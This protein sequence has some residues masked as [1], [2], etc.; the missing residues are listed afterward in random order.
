MKKTQVVRVWVAGFL[1][2]GWLGSAHAQ[3]YFTNVTA[4]ANG[5]WNTMANWTNASGGAPIAVN[6]SNLFFGVA[7]RNTNNLANGSSFGFITWTA[8]VT[9]RQSSAGNRY[10][11]NGFTNTSGSR[12]QWLIRT[13]FTNNLIQPVFYNDGQL[14]IGNTIT[15]LTTQAL[16]FDGSGNTTNLNPIYSTVAGVVKTGS[17][18]LTLTSSNAFASGMVLSN[19]LLNINHAYALGPGTFTIAKDGVTNNNSSGAAIVNANNNAIAW[20]GDFTFLGTRDLDLGTGAVTLGGGNRTVQVNA[21]TLALGGAIGDGGN[22]YGII[23][24]GSGVLSLAGANTYGGL[25]DIRTGIVSVATTG[26]LPG[27][28]TAGRY[29]VSNGAALAVG[30]AVT[31]GNVATI[32]ATGNFAAG[33]GIGFDTSAGNREYAV[34]LVDTGA[35][36]LGLAKVGSGQL[37]LSGANTYSGGT[38]IGGGTL[39]VSN[40]AALGASGGGL[41]FN[42]GGLLVSG[43]MTLDNRAITLLGMGT[44]DVEAGFT[45]TINNDIAGAGGLTKRGA[46]TL[47]LGGTN[48]HAGITYLYDGVVNLTGS[49]RWTGTGGGGTDFYQLHS[50]VVLNLSGDF[51]SPGQFRVGYESGTTA[52]VN[53]TSGTF[54]GAGTYGQLIGS[55]AGAGIYNLYGGMVTNNSGSELTLGVNDNSIGVFNLFGGVLRASTLEVGRNTGAAASTTNYFTQSGGTATVANLFMGRNNADS[56]N[57]FMN[58]LITN[59]IFTANT[60]TNLAPAAGDI[61]NLYFGTGAVVTLPAFPLTRG[62]GATVSLTMDGGT[63]NPYAASANYLSNLTSAVI[64]TNGAF[65]NVAAGK[66]IVIAQA[67]DNA[68]GQGGGSL[69]KL[70]SGTLQ[71]TGPNTYSNGTTISGGVLGFGAGALPAAGN[72]LIQEPGTLI[73]SGALMTAV[74]WLGRVDAASAGALALAGDNAEVLDLNAGSYSNLFIG[75]M[76]GATGTFSGALTPYGAT[77]RLGGGGGALNY[78]N[79]IGAGS[80]VV[81]AVG[82]SGT[83]ILTNVNTFAGGTLFNSGALNINSDAALG[84]APGAAATN[85]VFNGNSSLQFADSFALNANRTILVGSGV[86]A[87]LEPLGTTNTIAGVITGPGGI[88]KLG[89]GVLVLA[90]ANDF[91]GDVTITAGALA[92]GADN[93]LGSGTLVLA[94]G[95]LVSADAS[96][97]SINNNLS[98]TGDA[99]LGYP[100]LGNLT[101]TGTSGDLGTGTRVLTVSNAV[102]ATINNVLSNAANLAKA[103]GGTLVLGGANTYGGST[104]IRGGT[105]QLANAA[106]IPSSS[107]LFFGDSTV[108]GLGVLDLNGYSHTVGGLI[109]PVATWNNNWAI[110]NQVINLNP[111]Q[112][113]NVVSTANSNIVNFGTGQHLVMSGGGALNINDPNGAM[114]IMGRSNNVSDHLGLDVS[115]LGSF[116][117]SVSNIIVA[118]DKSGYGSQASRLAGLYLASNNTITA[119]NM[120]LGWSDQDGVASGRLLLGQS[121]TLN[122][123]NFIFGHFKGSGLMTFA[124][125]VVN[126]VVTLA[127]T[128]GT[129]RANVY[130]GRLTAGTGVNAFNYLMITNAG[131]A[132]NANLDQ[133]VIA[134][135]DAT[136]SSSTAGPYGEFTFNGGTVDVNTSVVGRSLSGVTQGRANG[137]LTQRGGVLNINHELTIAQRLGSG[138]ITGT[139]NFAGG[140]ANIYTN[141]LGGGGVSFLNVSGGTV[142]M[143]NHNIGDGGAGTISN[144]Y[145]QSGTVRNIGEINGGLTPL[146]KNT[147]GTLLLDTAN[148]YTGGTTISNG[149]L[150]A[151]NPTG[152]GLATGPGTINIYSG[153]SLQGTGAVAHVI[154]NNL[155]KLIPGNSIGT[156]TVS[157][158]TMNAGSQYDFEFNQAHAQTNDWII[159]LGDLTINGGAFNFYEEGTTTAYTINDTYNL[160][161]IGGALSGSLGSL[162]VNTAPFKQY[163]FAT[164]G[165][166]LTVT[167]AD[168]S[169]IW[170]GLNAEES[171]WSS[172]DNW[173]VMPT[174]NVPLVFTGTNRLINTNDFAANTKFTG[175]TF[176][177]GG[178]FVLEGNAL[179]LMSGVENHSLNLQTI[180]LPLVLDGASRPFGTYSN[181]MVINGE[182]S[183]VGGSWR[184]FKNGAYTLTLTASNNFSGGVVINAGTLLASNAYALGPGRVAITNAMLQIAQDLAIQSNL[185]GNAG[186][187]IDVGA[188]TLTL[189]QGIDST[190]AGAITNTGNLLMGGTGTVTLSGSNTYSGLTTLNAGKVLVTGSKAGAGETII[191]AGTLQIGDGAALNG[192]IAGN[193]S[194]DA[195]LIFATPT[196]LTYDG[197]ISGSSG[198]IKSNAGVL[199]LTGANVYNGLT[200]LAG[201]TLQIAGGDNR[202]PTT[203]ALL[204][205]GPATL[206]LQGFNQTLSNMT[207]NGATRTNFILGANSSLTVNGDRDLTFGS[208]SGVATITVDM[209]GL[210]AFTYNVPNRTIRFGPPGTGAANGALGIVTLAATNTITALTMGFGDTA[211]AGSS[212]NTNLLNLG[213]INAINANTITIGSRASSAIMTLPAGGSLSLRGTTGGA[214]FVNLLEL[215][216]QDNNNT[217]AKYHILDT[218]AGTLDAQIGTLAVGR[219]FNR[220]GAEYGTFQMGNGTLLASNITLGMFGGSNSSSY[221]AS[222]TF[223]LDGGTVQVQNLNLAESISNNAGRSYG[224]FVLSNGLLQVQ[225]ISR[226]VN[227]IGNGSG[228]VTWVGGVI[229]NYDASTDLLASNVWV[230]LV[231]GNDHNLGVGAGRTATLYTTIT[232]SG[233]LVKTGDGLLVLAGSSTF[234]GDT[235]LKAGT[236]QLNSPLAAQNSTISNLVAQDALQFGGATNAYT[237]GGLTD[238]YDL[239]LTNTAGSGITLSLGNSGQSLVFSKVISDAG[240]GGAINKVGTGDL[241]LTASNLHSGGSAVTGGRLLIGNPDALGKGTITLSGGLLASDGVTPR[242]ITNT[243]RVTAAS[244]LGDV[245][246]NGQLTLSGYVD[247]T[248]G[249]RPLTNAS[250]VIVTGGSGNGGL[251]VKQGAGTLTFTNG[252][253][254]WTSGGALAVEQGTV[255]FDNTTVTNADAFRIVGKTAGGTARLVVTNGAVL[256]SV[257]GGANIRLG[258]TGGNV[259]ATNILD[260]A[261]RITMKATGTAG[262]LMIGTASAKSIANLLPNGV[263]EVAAVNKQTGGIAEFNFAGG[264]LRPLEASTVFMTGLD[265][266]NVL[267]GGAII[268]SAYDITIGQSLLNGTGGGADGGLVKLGVG[269][270]TLSGVNTYNGLTDIR[271]G[272]LT[273]TDTNALPGWNTAGRYVVS[274]GAVLAVYNAVT[275]DS[276]TNMLGTGNFASG[277]YLGFDTASGNRDYNWVIADLGAN[278]LGVSKLGANNLVLTNVNTYTGGTLINGS[279]LI[280]AGNNA[281]LGTGLVTVNSGA[282]L[283]LTNGVVV[284]NNLLITGTGP[285][286]NGALRNLEGVNTYGGV[287]TLG[288]A[289][290]IQAYSGSTLYLTNVIDNGGYA[291]TMTSS[292]DTVVSGSITNSGSLIKANSGTLILEGAN[293][294]SGGTWMSAGSILVSNALALQNSTLTMTNGSLLF[295]GGITAATLGGLAG[296]SNITLATQSSEPVLLGV[297]NNGTD[298]TFGG[299]LSGAGGL[300]KIGAGTLTLTNAST[301]TGPTTVSAGTLFVRTPGSLGAASGGGFSY[302]GLITNNSTLFFGGSVSQALTGAISGSGTLIQGGSSYL[303]LTAANDYIGQTIVTSGVLQ[304]NNKD[305]LGSAVA[306]TVVSNNSRVDIRVNL[307]N[308]EPFAISGTGTGTGSAYGAIVFRVTSGTFKMT[309]PITLNGDAAL[310][311]YN[312]N[313]ANVTLDQGIDGTGSLTFQS[314]AG[315]NGGGRF[316]LLGQSSYTGDTYLQVNNVNWNGVQL[317]LG[318][319]NALPA[320]S[321]LNYLVQN[322]VGKT[323]TATLALNGFS[324]TVAGLVSANVA[325]DGTNKVVN[326]SATLSTLTINNSADHSF[327]GQLGAAGANDNNFALVKTGAGTQTLAPM[328]GANTYSG[329]TFINQGGLKVD[330]AGALGSGAISIASGARLDA[331]ALAT[332]YSLLSG[333]SLTNRGS[334]LGGL[335]ISSGALA[336]GGGSY[337]GAVTNLAGGTL[338]PGVG[339]DTNFFQS[340]TLAADSTNMFWIGSATT[341]DMSVVTNSLEAMGAGSP[342]LKLDLTNY[343]WQRGDE[344]VIYNNLYT[345]MSATLDG[346][347]KWFQF[348]DAFGALTN[349]YNNTYFNALTSGGA[350]N[351]FR[352]NYDALA[353]GDAQYNDIMLTAIPEPASFNLLAMLGAAYWLRRRIHRQKRRWDM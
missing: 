76:S 199:T 321:V 118:Y 160:I 266:A 99:L 317:H 220:M 264:I 283:A 43:D 123:A 146:I 259:A 21:N 69:T 246:N 73:A 45:L 272:T 93:V 351:M 186:A 119:N 282:G 26:T 88:N 262:E 343:N 157:N 106:A 100:G 187:I 124:P 210:G 196:A 133:L 134:T 193:I 25:T 86:S 172:N 90:G 3:V 145:F 350:T 162:S 41:T 255:V 185:L 242:T 265:T 71:L 335:I 223:S 17:G 46:G 103:G 276:I 152:S 96:A 147:A 95:A 80:L 164:N 74:G 323:N 150:V 19:G 201:G 302:A 203:T 108:N 117:A 322:N 62:A 342:L 311:T 14:Y 290:S 326:G 177:N 253:Q 189:N 229:S 18:T 315:N 79:A 301:Y 112:T 138:N 122:I 50:N 129:D 281:A 35:G 238:A 111:G 105:L 131:A 197:V 83:V 161:Q 104:A 158:L 42:N 271:T 312:S 332:G 273:I 212:S 236:L 252:I 219:I 8:N 92:L 116:N 295:G 222:G 258:Y 179:N 4:T 260:V 31:D 102:T 127:G 209:S 218:S 299:V 329:G 284:P 245:V 56:I 221:I 27:W 1:L 142:E 349:L 20:N 47:T 340:L 180:N 6:N 53:Q 211:L 192:F 16:V 275:D 248:T 183:E 29:V 344:F 12:V 331:T 139:V 37:I 328:L 224:N 98:F 327:D 75:M 247:F 126:G 57:Q 188:Y 325:G 159:T 81:G 214:S 198:L 156:L 120:Y 207:F 244:G 125:D 339:G 66:D 324:Q 308:A 77:Y 170:N 346:T 154:V 291:L 306:G 151:N 228:V 2:C 101:F 243:V 234:N 235:V 51:Y 213:Q 285:S 287:I 352:I 115:Q 277:S 297:G 249:A 109:L 175:I 23:K 254:D 269:A 267:A 205:T 292:G 345:G 341:H 303:T 82:G 60:F 232:N 9:N 110:T 91:A 233:N 169:Y 274:N 32:L 153:G 298:T 63:L 257:N 48:T 78:A 136:P 191:N 261:G 141:I 144:L 167:I 182:I 68:A 72:V 181:D 288:G 348:Q 190:F 149:V 263:L 40:D 94:G 44:N 239:V 270:L 30:N 38:Y 39:N 113:L 240:L 54:Y 89:A 256:I 163:T 202:L 353:N 143:N 294:F 24:T 320:T 49:N 107:V 13:H 87:G 226:G 289:A 293:T 58:L 237:I 347:N 65:F 241:T 178:A 286:G 230:N 176:T 304:I 227:N 195:T 52:I 296:N 316:T 307:T 300:T 330:V 217:P 84:A 128:G 130:I 251:G 336:M 337:A 61:A 114:L 171:Y 309:G 85:L 5:L 148:A 137:V 314:S 55:T 174:E 168:A 338:T 166:W 36:A 15:N 278:V 280:I 155:G 215:G 184:L 64:T 305:A 225:N 334:M 250:D 279:G 173:V 33:G 135:L 67:F 59:G 10:Y 216:K 310:N 28:D 319:N 165:V 204:F 140:T 194:N 132:L 231:P 70:G 208:T 7:G 11:F 318:T 313:L 200:T 34:A 206:D 268:D 333:Q 22:N 97:R 121:N